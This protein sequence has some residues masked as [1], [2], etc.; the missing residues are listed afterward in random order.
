MW[1][2]LVRRSINPRM[3]HRKPERSG[4]PIWLFG[5]HAVQAALANPTR[6]V[7]RYWAVDPS[8]APTAPG[9]ER[10]E[11]VDRGRIDTVLPKGSVHQGLALQVDALPEH[12]LET[13]CARLPGRPNLVVALDQITDP[14][15]LGAIL[16]S[17]AAFGARAVVTT[18]RHAPEA[19]AVVAK[20]ASG[21]LDIVPLVRVGNLARAMEQMKG[22][23]YWLI[24]L[25]DSGAKSLAETDLGGDVVLV[26]GAEGEGL[27]RLTAERCDA[28]AR[29]PTDPRLPALNVSNAAAVA[30]YELTRRSS[31]SSG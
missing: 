7:R 12:E 5:R 20:A 25:A 16:R 1:F 14:H 19:N 9:R 2:R 3:T 24:G 31:L 28:L 22:L 15:N 4:G 6:I 30:L 18:E 17:A 29:L 11:K 21:A 13:A 10:P 8:A 27:R 26:L 23:G